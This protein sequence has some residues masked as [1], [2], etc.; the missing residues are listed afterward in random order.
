MSRA[1]SATSSCPGVENG[2]TRSHRS[3]PAFERYAFSACFVLVIGS[4]L[5]HDAAS[6]LDM[7]PA[8]G[9]VTRS[10]RQT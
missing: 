6:R 2:F 10:E 7:N 8:A 4:W 5:A 1:P 9:A 3:V